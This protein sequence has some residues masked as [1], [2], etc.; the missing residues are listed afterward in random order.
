MRDRL[1][2][3]RESRGL[4]QTALAAR[5][6]VSRQLISAVESGRHLPR[7]D[8]A[9][10][11]AGALGVDVADLFSPSL[12]PVD[13]VTG[14]P[15]VDGMTVRVSRVGERMVIAVAGLG[16]AGWGVAD[17]VVDGGAVSIFGP[18]SPG[19]VVAGCEP[20]L[21]VLERLLREAGFGAL[22]A[23]SSSRA[24]LTALEGGR[25]HAAV[26]HGPDGEQLSVPAGLRVER[27]HLAR[28][29][30]G[31]AA[32]ADAPRGW[33]R[34]ALSGRREV[35]QR[36]Q[37]AGVQRAFEQAAG[38]GPGG[39]PGPR[40][41]THL[42]AA[43][44]AVVTGIPAVTIE[45]AARAVGAAFHELEVHRAE[46]WVAEEWIRDRVVAEAM[47]VVAGRRFQERLRSVGGYDL[48]GSGSR[49]A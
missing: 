33:W 18:T 45:P 11:L 42:E 40:V 15:P 14:R 13:A 37:G 38:A 29:R 30:V 43:R 41:A 35:I 31:L 12:D 28:W 48:A 5:A 27:F 4:S 20:G 6:G 49:A 21:E 1:R 32:P 34:Q 47:E 7:V 3:L 25:L 17:G 36:E 24:A 22:A 26:V 23:P 8:A 19:L 44:R 10:A 46:L 9:L 16:G 39:V 2:R